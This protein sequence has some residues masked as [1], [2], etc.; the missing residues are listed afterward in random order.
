M[1]QRMDEEGLLSIESTENGNVGTARVT[2]RGEFDL[3]G[4]EPFTTVLDQFVQPAVA[5]VLVDMSG[6]S[7]LDSSRTAR[8]SLRPREADQQRGPVQDCRP[9]AVIAACLDMTGTRS[10]LDG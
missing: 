4:V 9:S 8:A 2:L 7:F 3:N 10:I 5:T 1:V 6:V